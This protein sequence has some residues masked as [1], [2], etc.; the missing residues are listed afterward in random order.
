M[1]R[2]TGTQHAAHGGFTLIEIL[3]AI[4]I[5]AMVIGV[6]FS[7]FRV[8]ISSWEKGERD[9]E[10]YQKMRAVT[11]LLY[12]EISSTYP[13][14]ITPGEL[15]THKNYFAFFGAPNSIKFVSYANM[16]KRTSGLSLLDIWQDSTGLMLGEAGA[17]ASNQSDLEAIPIRDDDHAMVLSSDIRDISFRYFDR[18]KGD[19][20]GEWLEQW[21]PQDKN[22]RLPLFVEVT[23]SFVG[24]RDEALKE[25]VIVPIMSSVL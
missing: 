17:L 25:R 11:E 23:F 3:L 8:G 7:S 2:I 24:A 5:F 16:H 22:M 4:S 6:M 10:F 14:W 9:I 15:D 1:G 12:R 21:D 13:Y 19:E 20:E 18:K